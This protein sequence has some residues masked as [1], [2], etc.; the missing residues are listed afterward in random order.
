[1]F[2]FATDLKRSPNRAFMGPLLN[3]QCQRYTI[4]NQPLR[5]DT[6]NLPMMHLE[7]CAPDAQRPCYVQR[8][9]YAQRPCRAIGMAFPRFQRFKVLCNGSPG[10]GSLL[11]S[12]AME[13]LIQWA[14]YSAP[15][16][17]W[18]ARPL[19]SPWSAG[20]SVLGKDALS[21]FRCKLENKVCESF[22]SCC[23]LLHR[24]CAIVRQNQGHDC[25]AQR[26]V[27][28]NVTAERIRW[29]PA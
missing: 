11:S 4:C 3:L 1:M 7:Y 14:R 5:S 20:R 21:V 16:A 26:E 29:Q 18:G 28:G 17:Y 19:P 15:T 8:S 9:C 6:T 13:D 12:A 22:R 25:W 24:L 2:A 23:S 27:C 10:P